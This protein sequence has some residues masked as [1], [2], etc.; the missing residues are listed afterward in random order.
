MREPRD[1]TGVG[2]RE[3]PWLLAA[4]RLLRRR[5]WR[6]RRQG[7]SNAVL[8]IAAPSLRR[9]SPNIKDRKW[10]RPVKGIIGRCF[11]QGN[12]RGKRRARGYKDPG[13]L[14]MIAGC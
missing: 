13:R 10:M 2:T 4:R 6:Q 14:G 11:G 9:A 7:R 5:R 8:Y 1:Q 12:T 3:D